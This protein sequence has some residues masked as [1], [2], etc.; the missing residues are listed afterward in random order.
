MRSVYAPANFEW[1]TV[2][3]A[4]MH[5]YKNRKDNISWRKLQESK[6][7]EWAS[8]NTYRLFTQ[9]QRIRQASLKT[10]NSAWLRHL[11]GGEEVE[12]EYEG[13]DIEGAEGKESGAE[14]PD[15]PEDTRNQTSRHHTIHYGE[16]VAWLG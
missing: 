4:L 1:N 8:A 7:E 13:A 15:G 11:W 10:P 9:A 5:I 2:K 16:V 6:V 3:G 12:E 14:P